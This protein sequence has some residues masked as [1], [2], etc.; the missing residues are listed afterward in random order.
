MTMMP[1]LYL[2]SRPHA[3][4]EALVSHT[5]SQLH[6]LCPPGVL[7]APSFP[8]ACCSGPSLPLWGPRPPPGQLTIRSKK[9][10][11]APPSTKWLL[12]PGRRFPLLCSL[13]PTLQ[14]QS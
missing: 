5:C 1:L 11:N 7:N 9:E 2:E 3:F 13:T 14:A 12:S 4:E 10:R 6:A 8:G